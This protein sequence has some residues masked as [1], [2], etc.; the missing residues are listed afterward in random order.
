MRRPTMKSG[1]FV[2]EPL[3]RGAGRARRA[4]PPT[5]LVHGLARAVQRRPRELSGAPSHRDTRSDRVG[6]SARRTAVNGAISVTT[7]QS[8]G[9]WCL[10]NAVASLSRRRQTASTVT[11]S[12]PEC[13]GR[14]IRR[15][16]FVRPAIAIKRVDG[17]AAAGRA[18]Q[19]SSATGDAQN[20]HH[21]VA[22]SKAARDGV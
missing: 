9:A 2:E 20:V 3:F 10:K 15:W 21:D 12:L 11:W 5:G 13:P 1:R 19:L 6:P 22:G 7:R 14:V 17:R 16:Q 8:L 4:T 18:T